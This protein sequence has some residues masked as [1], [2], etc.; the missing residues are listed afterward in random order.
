MPHGGKRKKLGP[1]E[2]GHM[3]QLTTGETLATGLTRNCLVL[4]TPSEGLIL[5]EPHGRGSGGSQYRAI[6]RVENA[7]VYEG[8]KEYWREL[9]LPDRKVR[10]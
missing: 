9:P 3:R 2:P 6:E 7:E 4:G 1:P 8:L 5:F 10:G